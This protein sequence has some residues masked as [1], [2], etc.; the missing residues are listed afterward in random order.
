[1]L[2]QPKPVLGRHKRLYGAYVYDSKGKPY[3]ARVSHSVKALNRNC[4]GAIIFEVR[5]TARAERSATY[6]RV[7]K[8]PVA[9]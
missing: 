2:E 4:I 3:L 8:E 6:E 5:C 1:M 9:A 7:N